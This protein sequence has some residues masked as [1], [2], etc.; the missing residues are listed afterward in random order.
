MRKLLVVALV[1]AGAVVAWL[2]WRQQR[3]TP[4]IVSGFI[5]AEQIRVGSRVGG[6]VA[7]VLVSEGQRV[8]RDQPLYRIEP[9]DLEQRLARAE[10]ELA[11]ARAAHAKLAGGYRPQEL[12]QAR[13]RRD[14]LAAALAR[15]Q[16]GPRPGEIHIA[17][18]QLKIAQ[19]NLEWVQAEFRYVMSLAKQQTAAQ[20]EIDRVNRQLK[21][22]AAQAA[23]AE[24]ELALLREGT[25]KEEIAEARA[26]LA[27]AQ[28]ALELLEAG[29]Q[30]QDI[31]EAA[32]RVAAAVAEAEMIR[33]QMAELTVRSPAECVVEVIDLQAGDLVAP[34]APSVSLLDL[35]SMYVRTYVPAGQLERV[36]LG[37]RV[38]VRVDGIGDRL[39]TGRVTYIASEAEFTPRNIQT[40]E[41]RSKQVFRLK[42][43]LEEGQDRLRAGMMGDVLLEQ[44]ITKDEAHGARQ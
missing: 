15:A 41:E 14:R 30:A 4:L 12:E 32:A 13:A 2:L 23:A 22:A 39:F 11:A 19:A 3:V 20:T 6:R 7:E 42:V 26:A 44:G 34:N 27:E 17:E 21:S 28:A 10:A 29:Y 38:P 9:Y 40:P 43:V 16:A 24:Q 8:V 35:S 18:E 1:L 25:R 5:E 37:Q 33:R 36:R 31:E